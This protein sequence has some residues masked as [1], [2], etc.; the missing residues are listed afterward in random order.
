MINSELEQK[1]RYEIKFTTNIA[2]YEYL[3]QWISIHLAG[4]HTPYPPRKINNIYFDTFDLDSYLENMAGISSRTKLRLRWYGETEHVRNP[5]LELK[6]KRNKLGWKRAINI[7]LDENL[8]TYPLNSIKERVHDQLDNDMS[9]RFHH[10]DNPILINSYE[11]EYFL[12]SDGLVRVT[13]DRDLRFFD[14]RLNHPATSPY[15]AVSPEVVVLEVKVAATDMAKVSGV[16]K[17]LPLPPT[18]SSKYVI[19]VQSI[20]GF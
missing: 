4:F 6:I 3:H 11:R 8:S 1:A 19:G 17:D 18:K 16:L 12:S 5:S 10:S 20:L 7:E 13:L 14:P 2:H 15:S 9:N